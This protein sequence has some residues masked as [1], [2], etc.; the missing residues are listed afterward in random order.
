MNGNGNENFEF[1]L[2]GYLDREKYFYFQVGSTVTA[3]CAKFHVIIFICHKVL[4]VLTKRVKVCLAIFSMS[5][6]IQQRGFIKICVWNEISAAKM[7]KM[8]QKIDSKDSR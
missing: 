2:L 1:K 3:I 6:I 7:L 5:G 8:L 4:L